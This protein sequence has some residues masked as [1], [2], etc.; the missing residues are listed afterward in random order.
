[1]SEL[2]E[3]GGELARRITLEDI[4]T[5]LNQVADTL[6]FLASWRDSKDWPSPALRLLAYNIEG[7]VDVLDDMNAPPRLVP[8]S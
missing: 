6:E 1:M 3:P 2:S 7:C 4:A 8:S 5:R